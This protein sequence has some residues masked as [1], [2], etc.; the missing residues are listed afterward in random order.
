LRRK[1]KKV[2]DHQAFLRS[3]FDKTSIMAL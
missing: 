3:K 2:M 1:N